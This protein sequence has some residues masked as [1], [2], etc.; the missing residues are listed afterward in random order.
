MCGILG[1]Y[2]I[3]NIN[4]DFKDALSKINHRGPDDSGIDIIKV[5]NSYLHLGHNRL[6]IIDLS[7][8]GHQPMYSK[9]GRFVIVFNGEIYNYKELKIEIQNNYSYIF[10]TNTDTEVLIACWEIWGLE[11]LN[12]LNGMFAFVIFDKDKNQLSMFRD[13]FGIKPLYY[14]IE[15]DY[16]SFS[17]EI[18][19]LL[20][21]QNKKNKSN[22][23]ITYEYIVNGKY[24]Y[25]EETFYENIFK[26]MPGNFITFDLLRF[27]ILEKNSWINF[28][29]EE[30]KSLSY[31]EA[32]FE[33]RKEFLNNIKLQLRSDVPIGAALS[34]GLDS[35]AVVCAIRFLEPDMP[36]NTFTFI[37]KD[38]PKNEEIWADKINHFTNSIPH[39]I[40]VD[41][42]ELFDDLDDLI[43]I[44]G[45]PFMS[46]S[47]YAQYR[48]FKY[49]HE[50]GIT[51]TLDGQGADEVLAGYSGYPEYRIKSLIEQY[52][53]KEAILFLKN[54]SKWPNRSYI[55]GLMRVLGFYLPQNFY[56]IGLHITGRLY[57]ANCLNLNL[58]NP[59]L[60]STRPYFE[61]T[62]RFLIS[63][64]K[65]ELT[66]G[67]L[68]NLLRHGDRNSMRWSIESRVPFLTN[69][70]VKLMLTLPEEYLVGNNGETKKIFR[71]SMRGIVPNDVLDRKDKIGFETP[72]LDWL[73]KGKKQV[74]KITKDL[75]DFKI[76]NSKFCNNMINDTLDGNITYT[77]T[78][79]RIINYIKWSQINSIE[80]D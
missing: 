69:D 72:E 28:P 50:N 47:I 46:S 19:P 51:V 6:S 49:A 20:T 63:K 2:N 54:W 71:S 25:N 35:S 75:N 24:D 17:S 16:I 11:C 70:F 67:G 77:N 80:N 27:K 3:K 53:L 7:S 41:P 48:V 29:T 5:L 78:I 64:L 79:W 22:L 26:L 37:S 43:T 42:L 33:V 15:N 39:K 52:K 23:N 68:Q 14:Q 55:D 73:K 9:N 74:K 4:I 61:N 38:D 31:E 66:Q 59:N 12:K 18:P 44:Q 65:N 56:K 76:F 60:H 57:S 21:L 13:A 30:V 34:G 8:A 58:F 32:V 62:N 40:S 36:I 10:N 45:E 1:Y